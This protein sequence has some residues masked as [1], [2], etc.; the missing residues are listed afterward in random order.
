MSLNNDIAHIIAKEMKQY[1]L[2]EW[3]NFNILYNNKFT[4]LNNNNINGVLLLLYENID[5][6]NDINIWYNICILNYT[7]PFI[8]NGNNMDS[9]YRNNIIR[10]VVDYLD[11]RN[12]IS[13]IN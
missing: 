1:R 3:L 5:K 10:M 13:C 7:I 6:I 11:A 9:Y 2:V 8:Y 4:I 12:C